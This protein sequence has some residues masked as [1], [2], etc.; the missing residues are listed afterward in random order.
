MAT[1]RTL[2]ETGMGLGKTTLAIYWPITISAPSPVPSTSTTGEKESMR[3]A[4]RWPPARRG[5]EE[6]FNKW[7]SCT[8]VNEELSNV[9]IKLKVQ[10]TFKYSS[11][12]SSILPNV[13]PVVVSRYATF[14]ITRKFNL[15]VW[16]DDDSTYS[17]TAVVIEVHE[18]SCTIHDDCPT[19]LLS[20]TRTDRPFNISHS[21]QPE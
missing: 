5:S 11:Y 18:R 12:S 14:S 20:G 7:A 2:C 17:T 9:S 6:E 1:N 21:K 16:S 4:R 10:R 15:R 3:F 8:H 19:T 13:L